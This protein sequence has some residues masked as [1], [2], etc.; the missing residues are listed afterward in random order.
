M[1]LLIGIPSVF[2]RMRIPRDE[3]SLVGR[4]FHL[5][6]GGNHAR[7]NARTL[8]DIGFTEAYQIIDT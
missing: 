7:N 8:R 6:V 1:L 4:N 5:G 2:I 3:N